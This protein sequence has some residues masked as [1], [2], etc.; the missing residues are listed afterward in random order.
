M[1]RRDFIKTSCLCF[2][3]VLMM[4]NALFAA[5]SRDEKHD[6]AKGRRPV[7]HLHGH[8]RSG[9]ASPPELQPLIE[10]GIMALPY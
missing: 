6:R 4:H 2:G 9:C 5:P 8:A 1:L 10:N 7:Y 3:G